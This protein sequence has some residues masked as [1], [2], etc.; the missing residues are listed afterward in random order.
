V[1]GNGIDQMNDQ[2]GVRQT[3]DAAPENQ[4]SCNKQR[5]A[6]CLLQLSAPTIAASAPLRNHNE[7]DNKQQRHRCHAPSNG[8][9]GIVISAWWGL[10]RGVCMY[11]NVHGCITNIR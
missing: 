10:Q 7:I 6:I 3:A 1:Y 4:Q 8:G 11:M 9:Q 2:Q 5:A